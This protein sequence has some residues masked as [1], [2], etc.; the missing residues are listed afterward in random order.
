MEEAIELLSSYD[1][2]ASLGDMVHFAI[3][4]RAVCFHRYR[5]TGIRNIADMPAEFPE[6]VYIPKSNMQVYIMA[7]NTPFMRKGDVFIHYTGTIWRPPYEAELLL[8]E[9]TAGCS[10]HKCKFCTLYNELPFKYR[11]SPMK[12]IECELQKVKN[13]VKGWNGGRIDLV[14]L[15]GANP[16]VLS[17]EQLADIAGVIHKYLPSIN[18]IGSFA[19]ITDVT[20]KTDEELARLRALGYDGLTIGIETSIFY[21]VSISGTGRGEI[22]AKLTADICNQYQGQLKCKAKAK[23]SPTDHIDVYL[24]DSRNEKRQTE[25]AARYGRKMDCL[26]V[27]EDILLIWRLAYVC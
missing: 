5:R 14:F 13:A 9:V 1:M 17:Y 4:D 19:R 10:H 20:P 16:F 22:R 6:T 24:I 3:V 11:M 26:S 12:V 7:K 8:V 25:K 27:S 2:Q 23:N 18:S 15:T 21:L